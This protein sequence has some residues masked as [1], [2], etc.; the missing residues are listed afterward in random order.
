MSLLDCDSDQEY[1]ELIDNLEGHDEEAVRN[2]ALHK[3]HPV[4]R[5]GLNKNCSLINPQFYDSVR[6]ITNAVEQT[7]YKSYSMGRY[8]TLLGT[9][10]G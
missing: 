4:I 9:V 1:A 5:A 10:M 6:N 3:K 2:W 8:M 7:H